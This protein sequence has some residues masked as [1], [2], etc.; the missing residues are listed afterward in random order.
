[1]KKIR[2]SDSVNGDMQSLLG[3][4]VTIG[5][6]V[7]LAACSSVNSALQRERTAI[8]MLAPTEGNTASGVV[9][10]EQDGDEMVVRLR[11]EGLTPNGVHGL[12]IHEKGDCRAPDASSAGG[13]F[14]PTG[15]R[16]GGLDSDFRHAGD[17]GNIRADA[18]GKVETEFEVTGISL[19]AASN[20][21]IG[22]A[23]VVHAQADDLVSQPSGNAG[24]R[25]ACGLISKN[26][27]TFF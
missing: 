12:H 3:R 21:I 11:I 18:D 4:W 16:H 1:M 22:R 7:A 27:D 8:A 13:H 15:D 10:F 14:N 19:K 6:C 26:P 17:L 5:L 20:S 24:P 9:E 23:V 25:I 2:A